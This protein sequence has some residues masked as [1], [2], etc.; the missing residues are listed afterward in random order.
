MRWFANFIAA[1]S[2]TTPTTSSWSAAP[3]QAIRT[4]RRNRRPSHRASSQKGLVLLDRRPRQRARTGEA[5]R[6]SRRSL[7]GSSI[8]ISSS[9]TSSGTCTSGVSGAMLFHLLSKLYERTSVIVTTNLTFSEWAS[10]FGDAKMATAPLDRLTH[11]CRIL[12]TGNDSF[13]FKNSS[14]TTPERQRRKRGASPRPQTR[15]IPKRRGTAT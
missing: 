13:R 6:R 8:S 9:L 3:A 5:K 4:L 10:V 11:H 15:N 7:I 2:S 12:E 14:R 1:S